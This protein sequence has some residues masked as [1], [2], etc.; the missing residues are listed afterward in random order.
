M[1]VENTLFG[2]RDKVKT[3]IE[4]LQAFE[5]PEGYYLAFSGGKDSQC[6]YHLAKEAGV[7]FDAHYNKTTVDPPE[8]VHFIRDYYPDVIVDRPP[9]TMW[10]LVEKKGLPLRTK[11]W[12]CEVL[13]EH[14]GEDRICVTGVRWAESSRRK[15]TR[16]IAEVIGKQEAQVMLLNDN[17]EDRQMFENCQLK[18]KRVINPIIDWTDE[19]VW[20]YIR[21]RN[22]EY[23]KLY[24]E[25]FKR[26]GCIGCP[27]ANMNRIHAFER[28]P[29]FKQAYIRAI[30][31]FLPSYIERKK[32]KGKEPQFTTAEEMFDWWIYGKKEEGTLD[33][34]IDI[35]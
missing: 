14:G 18:G 29:K 26:L 10:Q 31:R 25:G 22:I 35:F 17:E 28:Y 24:D 23:C 32:A 9:K 33:G 30:S 21:S 20:E 2:V 15:N 34:Q 7:K 1:L 12:C 19:D 8:L 27:M 11:R 13:K 16:G 6:I 4:R 3:S 5:P